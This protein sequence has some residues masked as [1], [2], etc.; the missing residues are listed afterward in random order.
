M[1]E[2]KHMTQNKNLITLSIIIPLYK[3]EEFIEK[4]IWELEK[5]SLSIEAKIEVVFVDD[6]SQDK[7]FEEVKKVSTPHFDIKGIRL[8]KNFKS[9]IAIL[10]GIRECTGDYI[11]FLPQDLQ[12]P[13]DLVTSLLEEMK[14]GHDVVWA[15]RKSRSDPWLSKFLS[16]CFHEVMH[17]MWSE[18]PK[19]GADMFMINRPVADILISM[20]E[21]NSHITGQILWMGFRQSRIF[22]DRTSRKLGK[23]GWSTF[24]KIK[25]AIDIITQF[26]Y[27]PIRLCSV[28]GATTAVL[29]FLYGVFILVKAVV[30]GVAVTGWSSLMLVIL[31]LGGIQMIFLG[32]IGEYLWRTFD[33]VRNRPA[34]IVMEK[35]RQT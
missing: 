28:V 32:V 15:V 33:E 13:P 9:Y 7:T 5:F 10:A 25:L 16:G 29:G 34:Y 35:I 30:F 3:A 12:E 18:W 24:S 22:Y 6:G 26:S 1:A 31:L 20:Q 2:Q 8:S 21:K 23:S 11:T 14:N 19:T 27:A 17:S 4:L